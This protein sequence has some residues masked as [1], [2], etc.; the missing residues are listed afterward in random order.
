MVLSCCLNHSKWF[1]E[2]Q[3][4]SGIELGPLDSPQGPI[5]SLLKLESR[6]GEKV[7]G[8]RYTLDV[9]DPGSVPVPYM[10]S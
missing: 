8:A 5:E 4:M 1:F 10:V 3:V 7:Q 6:A 9:A 2:A